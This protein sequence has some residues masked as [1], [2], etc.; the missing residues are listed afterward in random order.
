MVPTSPQINVLI[1]A[2]TKPSLK[3][4]G[5]STY[6]AAEGKQQVIW[7]NSKDCVYIQNS[8]VKTVD[9]SSYTYY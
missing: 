3:I 7:T 5:S 8:G 2:V 4:S 9:F 6:P 1:K